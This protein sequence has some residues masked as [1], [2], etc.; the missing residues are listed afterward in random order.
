MERNQ[1]FLY[2]RCK[3]CGSLHLDSLVNPNYG[4]S[5][6]SMSMESY[7][8][9][10]FESK[11][12]MSKS[13]FLLYRL[14]PA[15]FRY[16]LGPWFRL[17]NCNMVLDFG[18]GNGKMVDKLLS[19]DLVGRD[20]FFYDKFATVKSKNRLD[21]NAISS[22]KF[23]LI[24]MSHVV[25]HL[26]WPVDDISFLVSRLNDKGYLVIRVPITTFFW[27]KLFVN[28]WVQ[29]DPPNHLSIP[30]LKGLRILGSNLQL[31]LM[32]IF[33]DGGDFPWNYFFR[34]GRSMPSY[35]KI[36]FRF[37][38][39]LFNTIGFSDQVSVVYTKKN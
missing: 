39:A 24:I 13:P 16:G 4:N 36:F 38:Q 33:F 9:N 8:L 31:E 10:Y 22:L 27:S 20:L 19:K 17:P 7:E 15:F 3:R 2:W 5:Y 25:E 35:L 18:A 14:F 11:M 21:L 28:R 6:Y 32:T 29:L 26:E 23:D 34:R 37:I 30:S 1:G 12:L